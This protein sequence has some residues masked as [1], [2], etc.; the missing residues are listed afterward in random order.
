MYFNRNKKIVSMI[1]CAAMILGVGFVDNKNVKAEETAA[2]GSS[3]TGEDASSS[4]DTSKLALS[5]TS[6]N[7]VKGKTKTLSV[8]GLTTTDTTTADGTTTD[9][10]TATDTTTTTAS[11][12]DSAAASGN[13]TTN[14]VT[15]TWKSQNEKIATVTEAGVVKG[16]KKGTTTITAE[17]SG[18]TLS[19]AVNVVA[20]MSKKDFSKFSSE[21]FVN[22]C[23]RK[24]YDGGYAWLGQWKG[25]SK[26]KTTY[27]GIKIDSKKSKVNKAY[28]DLTWSKCTSKDPF[29]KMKGLKKNK[30]KKYADVK[31]G[32]YRIRFY[33]NSK[34]KVVAIILACNIGKIKKKALKQYI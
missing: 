4:I 5:Q 20:K 19:C 17:I 15:V 25:G 12:T 29:T 28:G 11:T 9:N 32:K 16:V 3:V 18:V 10:T 31:Y 33:I 26:K 24:G 2:T 22:F 30:V 14:Q 23:Q 6:M 8:T 13:A 1:L 34:N 7:L 27:R 21:N